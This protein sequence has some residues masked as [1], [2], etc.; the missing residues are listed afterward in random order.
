M[1]RRGGLLAYQQ[2]FQ[3]ANGERRSFGT[4]GLVCLLVGEILHARACLHGSFDSEAFGL[5]A[6]VHVARSFRT[7]SDILEEDVK[8]S[9]INVGIGPKSRFI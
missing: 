7:D 2:T 8:E 3:L 5:H 4:Y 6:R 9:I 1:M